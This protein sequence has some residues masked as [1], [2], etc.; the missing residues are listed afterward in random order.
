M[1]SKE[2]KKAIDNLFNLQHINTYLDLSKE[3]FRIENKTIIKWKESIAIVLNL[4]NKLQNANEKL[5]REKEENKYIIA[6]A[7]N[8]ML[9][10]IQGYS[11]A[12][13][14]NSNATE[15]IVKNRQE[16]I[17]KE[18]IEFYKSKIKILKKENENQKENYK[19][20]ILDVSKIAI[21]LGLEEDGTIDEIYAKIREKDK[22]IDLMAEHI[23]SSSIV[24]DTVCAIKCDCESDILEDCSHEKM[25]NCTKEYFKRK[26]INIG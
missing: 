12:K 21:E 26:A 3:S 2:E 22:Q 9:G 24:D 25:L 6:M 18:E 20:L 23:V 8:E 15:I 11:D 4:I 13:N 14:K 19:N 1:L 10:Y 16:Y 5:K 17:H 7:N